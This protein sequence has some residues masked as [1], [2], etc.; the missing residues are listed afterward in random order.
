MVNPLSALARVLGRK[1]WLMKLAKAII[2]VDK[3]LYRM[4]G[5]RVTLVGIAGLPSLRLTTVGRR[6]GQP[7]STNLLYF[8]HEDG[9]VLVGSNWGRTRDPGWT[10]NLRT[11][12][13]AEIEVRGRRIP[14]RA[15]PVKGERYDELW[16]ELLRFWP[17]YAMEQEA[18]CRELPI[19]LLTRR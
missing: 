2:W 7:R 19:F 3:R 12:P 15:T 10:F 8:P 17:G 9:Y 1:P 11:H 16:G 13:E 5:G 4:F 18:A 6:S 14:V